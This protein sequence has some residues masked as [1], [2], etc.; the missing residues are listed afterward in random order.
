[1]HE[2]FRYMRREKKIK[3]KNIEHLNSSQQVHDIEFVK[4]STKHIF[5]RN[6]RNRIIFASLN[7]VHFII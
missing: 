5:M 7:F 3:R 1:M 2:L 4:S 6:N